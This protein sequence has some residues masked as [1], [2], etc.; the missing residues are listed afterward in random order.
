MPS[1]L[2]LDATVDERRGSAPS[3]PRG[4]IA[5]ADL[6]LVDR[7]N[8]EMLDEYARG[9]LGRITRARDVRTGRVVAIKE[10]LDD[11]DVVAK[12]FAREARITANLQHPAIVPVYEIGRWA[13]GQPF[14]AMK[15]V[16]G[17]SLSQVLAETKTREGRLGLLPIV[18]A[19][20]D[21]LAYAHDHGVIHRD[22]KPDNVLTGPFGETVVVDWGL[23]KLVGDRDPTAGLATIGSLSDADRTVAGTVLGTPY[24]MAPEQWRGEDTDQRADVYAIGAMLY[25]LVTGAP[26]FHEQKPKNEAELSAWTQTRMPTPVLERAP[27][28]PRDLATIVTKALATKPEDRYPTARELADDLRRFTG[29]QLV[30]AHRYAWRSLLARFVRRYRA[31]FAVGAALMTLLVIGGVISVRRIIT[32][33][34]E[35][36]RQRRIAERARDDENAQRQL[37]EE[38]LAAAL[39]EKGKLAETQQRWSLAA[40]YYAASRVHRDSPEARWAAGLAEA[41]SIVPTIRHLDHKASITGG[42]ITPDGNHGITIDQAGAVHVWSLGNGMTSAQLQLGEPL[43]AIAVSPDGGELAVAGDSGVVHRYSLGLQSL[44]EQRGHTGRVWS[45]AYAPDGKSLASAGEDATIRVT[46]LSDGVARVLTGHRQ[47]VYSIAFSSDGAS[48]VSGSDDRTV[49]VWDVRAGAGR[50][51]GGQASGGIKTVGFMPAGSGVFYGGWGWDV[52]ISRESGLDGWYDTHAVHGMAVTADERVIISAGDSGEIHVWEVATHKLI[53]AL[54]APG[55]TTTLALSRDGARLL[56]AGDGKA[57]TV[58]NLAALPRLVDAGHREGVAGL[59]FTA[60]GKGL[61]SGSI[62]H[63]IRAWRVNDGAELRRFGTGGALCEHP[64]T[65]GTTILVSC[66]DKTT[67]RWDADRTERSLTTSGFKR[68]SAVSP[69]GAT[70]ATAHVEGKLALIDLAT[71]RVRTEQKLHDHQIYTVKYTT[72]GNIVTAG[73]DN[74]VRVWTPTLAPVKT[75]NARTTE[76]VMSAAVNPAET[77]IASGNQDGSLDVWDLAT[78]S[79]LQHITEHTARVWQLAFSP[80]G[81]TLFSGSD[82]G[83]VALWDVATWKRTATLDALEGGI[84]GL[85]LSPDGTTLATGHRSSGIVWW[86]LT[87]RVPRLRVGGKARTH[88]SCEDMTAQAW[89]DATHRAVVEAACALSPAD[90]IAK[91]SKLTH[92]EMR[93]KIEVGDRW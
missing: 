40:M 82:D 61:V 62:D 27:A 56:T 14:Y 84:V 22:L 60:D 33:R 48:L 23:A 81:K 8:Y 7:S 34:D 76:G 29:G 50:E 89:T 17:R 65:A 39:L 58:W 26:P 20:A 64:V 36:N 85:A 45:L 71:W 91:L 79:P 37:A 11:A 4:D 70:L 12:R 90:Y 69:D 87:R 13:D 88:G 68:Y 72:S 21:A 25:R 19:V 66:D 57:A 41:R 80:D 32:E 77:L 18:V 73:L 42:A 51:R 93:A 49:R 63:T 2:E 83:T 67:R 28:T 31:A 53:T 35:A 1:K 52:A 75:F 47:R 44:G 55:R 46:A 78:G 15:L 9:G 24:Y 86:D 54:P 3:L 59:A 6:P 43:V 16:E 74:R 38:G 5:A 30:G 92:L 10:V